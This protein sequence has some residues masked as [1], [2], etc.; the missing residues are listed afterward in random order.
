MSGGMFPHLF[1]PGN[2]GTLSLKNRI[3]F[4]ATSSELADKDGFVSD[5]MV[6]Y[7]AERARGGTGLLVVEATY[8]EQEGKRLHHNAM[9]HDDRYIPGLRAIAQAAQT[10]GAK[11][12][13]QLNHGGRE[14]VP[15]ISG[16]VPL[17]PSAVPSHFT[18]V[19]D[20]VIPKALTRD[21]IAR[22]KLRF[23]EAAIRTRAAGYDAIELH[24]A[25]GYLIGQFLSPEANR[26]DDEYGGD[27]RRR[28][29]FYVDLVRDIKRA[30]GAD[31]PIICRM[32][33]SDAAPGGLEL[34][35][36]CT[37]AAMLEDAGAD[38][39][40]ISG[41]IHSSRPYGIV[42]GMCVPRGCYVPY[43]RTLMQQPH[44]T[45]IMVVGRINTPELAERILADG[46]ADYI[47]L[48]RS[49]L[50]DPYFPAKAEVGEVDKIVPCIACNECLATI[51]HH[52]GIACTVN[53]MA[54]RELEFREVL[55]TGA[56]PKRVV[57]IGGGIAGMAAAVTAAR[58]GH[59]V[60]L[61]EKDD[62]LGG[63]LRLAY[64]PPNREELEQ[65]LIYF[66][67]EIVRSGVHVVCSH[68][69]TLDDVARLSPNHII[70]A[71]GAE[72][73]VP[74]IPGNDLPHVVMGWQIIAGRIDGGQ[75]CAVVGGGLVGME[76]ADYL[77]HRG[78]KVVIIARSELLTKAVH[79]D[80]VYFL[81]R[82]AELG[83]EVRTH[84]SI[85][86]ITPTMVEIAGRDGRRETLDG[87]DSVIFCAGYEP[88]SSTA[89][90]FGPL[91]IPVHMVG[92]V[93]GSRKFF[94]AVEEGTLASLAL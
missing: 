5:S 73:R 71:T 14:C 15:E 51:H 49:L 25:H 43:G 21:E 93:L 28:A 37:I 55:D 16:S 81:D 62:V 50:A 4:A 63:Q 36:A 82:I 64:L 46:D 32:N 20:P 80:R 74:D 85:V 76:V 84:T 58:R 53:P 24:G 69:A 17:A 8:V 44:R 70:V 52:D 68:S 45:P 38:S 86:A 9:L 87:V 30:L 88:R 39:I 26:R 83:I 3:V 60:H 35:E 42:P 91:G 40:S 1:T 89:A 34:D 56:V 59:D 22:I 54:S 57:V 90:L 11:I 75:N 77:A 12:A 18:A 33:G 27:T 67:R 13:L 31:Y 66:R 19:G 94:Q 72:S 47:C 2:I 10:A 29:Q 92:D 65:A 41:G 79:A 48:S 7:Y 23:V 6:E 78:R 61:F